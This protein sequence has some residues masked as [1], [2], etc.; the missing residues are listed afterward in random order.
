MNKKRI[1][2]L[3]PQTKWGPYYIYEEITTYLKDKFP[4]YEIKLLNKPKDWLKLQLGLY[5][6]IDFLFSVIPF[7]FRPLNV[8]NYIFNPRWNRE[9]EKHKKWIWNKLLYFASNNLQCANKIW[10]TSYFL[11]EKLNFK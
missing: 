3:A 4:S 5:G 2:F 7:I 9:I 1:F 11:A 10:L 8:K 6:K